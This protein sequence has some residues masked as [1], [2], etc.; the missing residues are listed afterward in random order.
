MRTLCAVL[1]VLT[2]V[3]GM[4]EM[5]RWRTPEMAAL[6][7]GSQRTRRTVIFV[8]LLLVLGIAFVG[9]FLP[10]GRVSRHTAL[11]ELGYWLSCFLFAAVVG[12]V[13]LLE[14]R[15]SIRE[16]SERSTTIERN[17]AY[18]AM[19]ETVAKAKRNA[20]Q[21]EKMPKRNGHG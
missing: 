16:V 4:V 11:F 5:R 20:E 2:I 10:T 18:Q 7:G 9:T 1:F 15:R 8:L 19:V 3:Y 12:V 17:E 21:R 13:A 14:F 6:L